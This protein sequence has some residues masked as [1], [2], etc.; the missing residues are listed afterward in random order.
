MMVC[1]VLGA[2][3]VGGNHRIIGSQRSFTHNGALARI[4]VAATAEHNQGF[5]SVVDQGGN[6]GDGVFQSIRGVGI[7]NVHRNAAVMLGANALQAT[8]DSRCIAKRLLQ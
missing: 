1:R 5:M 3:V 8:W 4:A 6:G 2:G 7:V